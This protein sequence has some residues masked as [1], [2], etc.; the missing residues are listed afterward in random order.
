MLLPFLPILLLLLFLLLQL[1]LLLH[2][3]FN[4]C[5]GGTR[6]GTRGG[7]RNTN[8]RIFFGNNAPVAN[9]A[10][11]FLGGFAAATATS[12]LLGSPCG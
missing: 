8:N 4:P 11:G 10:V 2:Q 3:V 6:G 1:L 7:N 9:G 5:R 12:F